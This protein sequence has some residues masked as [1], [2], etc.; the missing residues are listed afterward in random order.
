[1]LR[2]RRPMCTVLK[3]TADPE[4]LTPSTPAL[5]PD[6]RRGLRLAAQFEFL[7]GLCPWFGLCPNIQRPEAEPGAMDRLSPSD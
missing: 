4:T 6:V 7:I 1:M 5:P 2:L 3:I